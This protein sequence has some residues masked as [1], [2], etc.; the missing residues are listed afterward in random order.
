MGQVILLTGSP[1]TGKSSLRKGLFD[2]FEDVVEVDYGQELLAMKEEEG[3]KL[4]YEDLRQ[5][6]AAV[7][8][9]D[10]VVALDERVIARVQTLRQNS[11]LVLDSH[12]VTRE[13][14]GFRAIPFSAT[15]IQR[16]APSAIIVLRCDPEVILARIEANGAGRRPVTIE[17]AR[18]HQ[19]LQEAIA[20]AYAIQ[21]GCPIYMIDTSSKNQEEVL[22]EASNII[23]DLGVKPKQIP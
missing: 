5:N 13:A 14:Y 17:L 22:H 3:L 9:R 21:A 18:E 2:A 10:H 1:A 7:I 11:T 6:P 15:Q 20:V 23:T 19:T 16:L 12:A 4:T 8:R